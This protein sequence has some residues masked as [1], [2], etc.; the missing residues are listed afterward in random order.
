[1]TA[2]SVEPR[3]LEAPES[4][5]SVLGPSSSERWI[6]CPASVR[7]TAGIVDKGSSFA[8][9]GTAAHAVAEACDHEGVRAEHYLGW[10]VRVRRGAEHTDVEC[11]QEMVDGVNAF[12]DYVDEFAG[13]SLCE[14]RVHYDSIV[15]GGFGTMDR[16]KIEPG[17]KRV[18]LFDLKY[19]KGVPVD[20]TDNPQLKLYALGTDETM[21]WMLEDV[22]QYVLHV[23]QPRLDSISS[24]AISREDLYRWRDEVA[25]PQARKAVDGSAEF[26]AGSWCTFCKIRATCMVRANSVFSEIVGDFANLDEAVTEVETLGP[27]FALTP[28]QASRI[29]H[30]LPQIKSWCSDLEEFAL[31]ELMQGRSVGDWKLVEGRSSRKWSLPE[32][33]LA[34]ML[35][36]AGVPETDIWKRELVSVAQ[37]EKI[38]MLG[39]KHNIFKDYVVKTR[40]KPT[41][42]PGSDKRAS[43]SVD[44]ATEFENLD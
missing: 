14:A 43:I 15:E 23:V 39:K 7:A 2:F 41:L 35:A 18:H 9:E 6:E 29:L 40:G 27:A 19:G 21:G 3:V 17:G 22:E 20:A 10:T 13:D 33:E 36:E 28:D 37:A 32:P 38:K 26:K 34:A 16:G 5:H 1:M 44:A 11:D 12:L 30:V 4:E 42:A 25:K 8:I 24:W 31:A